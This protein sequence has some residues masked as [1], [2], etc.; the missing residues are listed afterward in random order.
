M[1][2]L[3]GC[4]ITILALAGFCLVAYLGVQAYLESSKTDFGV[5]RSEIGVS[6]Y[7]LPKFVG[8]IDNSGYDVSFPQC[9]TELSQKFVGFVIIGLNNGRP[10]TTNPCFAKQWAWANEHTARAVYIN[11]SDPGKGS[12]K[13]RGQKIARDTIG[14]LGKLGVPDD[15]P[16]WLD[17]EIDNDWTEPSRATVVINEVLAKLVAAGHPVG[18]YSVPVHWFHITFSAPVNVPTWLGLGKYEK[19]SDGV[20]AAKAACRRENFG[21][22]KP[23]I[24]QFVGRTQSG[25]LDRNILCGSP[26]GLVARP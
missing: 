23:A 1:R 11:V 10:F 21:N 20:A 15:V 13:V 9:N 8:S 25:W 6:N 18:I 2:R 26:A 12:A 14:R 4:S 5:T 24:V 22:R 17:V 3:F 19:I 7:Q 16:I